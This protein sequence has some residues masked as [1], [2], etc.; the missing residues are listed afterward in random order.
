M[1]STIAELLRP[2]LRD[3]P[4][5]RVA[6]CLPNDLDIVVAFH[7]AQRIGAIWTGINEAYP[8]R[9]QRAI[10]RLGE[11]VAALVRL[12]TGLDLDELRSLCGLHL[13]RY[14]VPEVWGVVDEFPV[15]AMG[16]IIRTRLPGL[17]ED[18]R[19]AV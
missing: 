11:K 1:T 9:G 8:E 2:A 16:K 5:D 3:R 17:L 10:D 18:V 15:N 14:K 12:G 19:G 13:A 7:G 6:A 4:G